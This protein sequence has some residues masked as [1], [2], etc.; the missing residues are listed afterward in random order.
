MLS[1]SLTSGEDEGAAGQD[2]HH[3]EGQGLSA[4]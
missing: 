1:T 2:E 3:E 4:P